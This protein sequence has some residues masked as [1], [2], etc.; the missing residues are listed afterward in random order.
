MATAFWPVSLPQTMQ[1]GMRE[2]HQDGTVRSVMDAGPPKTR[3][4]YTA[5]FRAQAGTMIFTKAQRA[6]FEIFFDE[7]LE[8]GANEFKWRDQ[9]DG[10]VYKWIMAGPPQFTAVAADGN[11]VCLWRVNLVFQRVN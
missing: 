1:I 5:T 8:K 3:K 10:R 11:G 7:T 9:A 4:R 6:T 2:S